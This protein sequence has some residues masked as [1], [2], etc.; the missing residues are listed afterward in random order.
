MT[1]LLIIAAILFTMDRGP[2]RGH[3]HWHSSLSHW[4]LLSEQQASVLEHR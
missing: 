1:R 2:G 4:H 3:L